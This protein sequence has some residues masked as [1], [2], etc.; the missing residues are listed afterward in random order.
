MPATPFRTS[1]GSPLLRPAAPTPQRRPP[2]PRVGRK[3]NCHWFCLAPSASPTLSR[4]PKVQG[5]PAAARDSPKTAADR[6]ARVAPAKGRPGSV[7]LAR[8]RPEGRTTAA[9]HANP[10]GPAQAPAENPEGSP[11]APGRCTRR[12]PVPGSLR[13]DSEEP[14]RNSSATPKGA[15]VDELAIRPQ[16][17][18]RSPGVRRVAL[19]PSA[20]TRRC[21]TRRAT[22]RAPR[23]APRRT[24]HRSRR[25]CEGRAATIRGWRWL[26]APALSSKL[27]GPASG[28]T[29]IVP[30]EAAPLATRRQ[31][32]WCMC[33]RGRGCDRAA[34]P[35]G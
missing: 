10:E 33:T 2:H 24:P 28:Q 8:V 31:P 16:N 27:E 25:S 30:I 19:I 34:H 13:P 12:R 29:D 3:A 4:N 17:P 14:S 21:G 1:S 35:K 9:L 5:R 23:K 7:A 6:T 11:T 15:P 26:V 20:R 22:R 32:A 18:Q